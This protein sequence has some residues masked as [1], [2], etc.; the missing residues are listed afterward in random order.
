MQTKY[1]EN[2]EMSDMVLGGRFHFNDLDHHDMSD[3]SYRTIAAIGEDQAIETHSA[4]FTSANYGVVMYQKT[5]LVFFYLKDYLGEEL[6][7]ACMQDY[8]DA[9]EF[10]HPQPDDMRKSLE[11]SSGKVPNSILPPESNSIL[12]HP[13]SDFL[14]ALKRKKVLKGLSL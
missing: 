7:D 12:F 13:S 5:G 3:I 6:F 2:T 10:R 9:W 4:R 1:P 8:Y 14:D 11:K